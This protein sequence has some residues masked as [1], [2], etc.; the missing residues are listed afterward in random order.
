MNS[1]SVLRIQLAPRTYNPSMFMPKDL[2][3]AIYDST[4][5]TIKG[6]IRTG[7]RFKD[8]REVLPLKEV[9]FNFEHKRLYDI[10]NLAD[11]KE[12]KRTH[13]K[14]VGRE[15]DLASRIYEEHLR[16]NTTI[17]N[18][19]LY[20]LVQ[21]I[22]MISSTISNSEHKGAETEDIRRELIPCVRSVKYL[23]QAAI[24][25]R[26]TIEGK[27]FCRRLVGSLIEVNPEV[28]KL[29][30]IQGNRS[31]REIAEI[32]TDALFRIEAATCPGKHIGAF[33]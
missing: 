29:T 10:L 7:W 31:D 13:V 26:L 21:G 33:F 4:H 18:Y 2:W 1:Y 19:L 9:F 30:K 28:H 16:W 5:F 11:I 22:Y 15:C 14:F 12:R 25:R 23:I 32:I 8:R 3:K 6:I 20:L 27:Q 17:S 24:M